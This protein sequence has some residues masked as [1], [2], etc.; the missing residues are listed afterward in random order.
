MGTLTIPNSFSVGE[1]AFSAQVN[2]NFQAIASWATT[3]DNTN[4]GGSGIFASQIIPTN[5]PQAIFGGSQNYQVPKSLII[6]SGPGYSFGLLFTTATGLGVYG[7]TGIPAFSAPTGSLAIRYDGTTTTLYTNQS[8]ASSSGTTWVGINAANLA[9]YSVQA[10]SVITYTQTG[11]ETDA[12]PGTMATA[13]LTLPSAS[14]GTN[15]NWRVFVDV[16]FSPG[17]GAIS[18]STP[19]GIGTATG[20]TSACPMFANGTSTHLITGGNCVS[21]MS[22]GT[23]LN[24]QGASLSV[25][26]SAVYAN[27]ATPSFT[28]LQGVGSTT[29]V[30]N[31]YIRAWALPN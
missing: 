11:S 5:S 20:G 4:I 17:S 2:A 3:I 8:G 21:D 28:A 14:P 6:P 27:S 16:I 10:T 1:V 30:L 29:R 9:P 25:S 15:G 12:S 13:A 24:Y 7:G 22:V 19:F 31:G 18:G 23:V 26:Y